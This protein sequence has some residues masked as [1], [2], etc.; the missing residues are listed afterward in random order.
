LK[1]CIIQGWGFQKLHGGNLRVY[2]LIKELLKRGHQL[3]LIHANKED[4]LFSEREFGCPSKD[5]GISITRFESVQKKIIKYPIFVFRAQRLLKKMDYDVVF[6]IS[7]INSLVAVGD[8]GRSSAI[9]YVDFMSNYY[10]YGH[11]KG[12]VN[13]F[14]FK[15]T[16]SLERYTIRKADRIAVITKSLR[17]LIDQ[18][19]WPRISIIPDGADTQQFHPGINPIA[20][21]KEFALKDAPV[22]G[23]QGGIEPFDGLQFLAQA[24]PLVLREIPEAQFLVVGKGTYQPVVEKIVQQNNTMKNFI[25]TGWLDYSRMPETLAAT[26]LSVVPIPDC[27]AMRPLLTFRLLEAMAAGVPII[28]ND[29]PGVREMV[30]ESMA[31]FT[32][33]EDP[34]RFGQDIVKALK[35]DPA[36][37]K[38]RALKARK[39][40]E[41]FDWRT[42]GQR[43]ADF[44]GGKK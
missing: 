9:L 13:Y 6:G 12:L 21:K 26:S 36:E 14:I 17:D 15:A 28:V 35:T 34:Q 31:F 30:D 41:A 7:L 29:L 23:Y 24:A 37:L 5:V 25:F 33:V 18:K 2:F 42:I 10:R 32:E 40:I 27:P 11:P 4:A 43:D 19:E 44:I 16:Q 1:I 8:N 38:A 22:I 3:T 20:F 39:I